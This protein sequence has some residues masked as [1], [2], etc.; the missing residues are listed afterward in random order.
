M[1]KSGAKD[2]RALH[3]GA[4]RSLKSAVKKAIDAHIA[5]GVP[6]A[7]WRDGKVVYIVGKRSKGKGSRYIIST[8]PAVYKPRR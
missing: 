7:I 6:A 4:V 1:S 8:S 5:A 3:A 2:V